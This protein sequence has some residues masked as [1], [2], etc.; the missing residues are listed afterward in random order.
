MIAALAEADKSGEILFLQAQTFSE[1]RRVPT[2]RH[3]ART[4][5]R[6]HRARHRR[7]PPAPCAARV[8]RRQRR[9]EPAPVPRLPSPLGR[10]RRPARPPRAA[11]LRHDSFERTPWSRNEKGLELDDLLAQLREQGRGV[12]L[13]LKEGEAILADVLAAV[14]AHGFDDADLWFNGPGSRRSARTGSAGSSPPARTPSCSARST[15]SPR[16]CSPPP[17]RPGT[18]SSC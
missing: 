7:R 14:D 11:R 9:S 12:K 8:A 13:D 2:P 3:R 4:V 16:S 1:S 18:R 17:S 10:M 6:P 15:S 5:V